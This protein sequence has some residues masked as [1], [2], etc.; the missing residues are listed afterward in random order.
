MKKQESI[1]QNASLTKNQAI[2]VVLIFILV[3]ILFNLRPIDYPA[4]DDP[5][6]SLKLSKEFLKNPSL[7]IKDNLSFSSRQNNSFNLSEIVIALISNFTSVSLL[8]L[9]KIL[10]LL[11]AIL[12]VYL[13][14]L[15]LKHLKFNNRTSF[16]AV[17]L[18]IISPAFINSLSFNSL[19]LF[20]IILSAYLFLKSKFKL[21]SFILF[22]FPLISPLIAIFSIAI[23]SSFLL[24]KDRKNLKYVFPSFLTVI[25]YAIFLM[26]NLSGNA[27]INPFS[28]LNQIISDFGF[29]PGLSLFLLIPSVYALK[30]LWKNNSYYKQIFYS[31]SLLLIFSLFST[32][33]LLVFTPIASILAAVGILKLHN[34][35]WNSNILKIIT[36]AAILFGICLSTFN[37]IVLNIISLP[38]EKIIHGL[39]YLKENSPE[40]S[41][42]LSDPPRGYWINYFSERK[43]IA[44]SNTFLAPN[45][46]ERLKDINKI[47]KTRDINEFNKIVSKY[48]I[49]YILI[50]SELKNQLWKTDDEGLLF[51][52]KNSQ[53]IVRFYKN[54]KL[55]IW[56]IIKD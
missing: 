42:V 6:L 31:F 14:L 25:L 50:D 56:K 54:D 4:G 30:H 44:D 28:V 5:Y 9:Y 15:I 24:H 55:E 27:H 1:A 52:L 16:L 51:I 26:S 38:D 13:F 34:K 48:D 46:K 53:N 22:I 39:T 19:I 17:I 37:F 8:A 10:S 40:D 49:N 21:L 41:V 36:V 35:K 47:F 2:V 23:L 32:S 11:F 20:L 7:I 33:L 18:L 12:S 43:N 3:L 29:Y 45:M